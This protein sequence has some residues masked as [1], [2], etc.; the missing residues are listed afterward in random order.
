MALVKGNDDLWE[1]KRKVIPYNPPSWK[2]GYARKGIEGQALDSYNPKYDK[3]SK[4]FT[5][6]VYPDNPIQMYYYSYLLYSGHQDFCSIQH[7]ADDEV[8]QTHIHV[9]I[10]YS[11]SKPHCSVIREL[12]HYNIFYSMIV[13]SVDDLLIY[14]CHRD[15]KSIQAG[16]KLYSFD[17]ITYTGDFIDTISRLKWREE[18]KNVI[19]PRLDLLE[20]ATIAE[21]YMDFYRY[22]LS[23]ADLDKA[24]RTHQF[25]FEN[26][27]KRRFGV[28]TNNF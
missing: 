4:Y 24:F 18:K 16:K 22:A 5:F 25:M 3:K 21:S 12:G 11:Y 6:L 27:L 2:M 10:K 28:N 7:D 8:S 14:F 17:D 26:I 19:T 1:S 15:L 9:M 23:D 13:T 20:Y